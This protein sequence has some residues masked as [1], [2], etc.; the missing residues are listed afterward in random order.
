MKNN[1]LPQTPSWLDSILWGTSLLEAAGCDTPRLDA[2]ILL[3]HLLDCERHELYLKD[4]RTD[5]ATTGSEHS[6]SLEKFRGVIHRR[7]EREPVSQ[8]LGYK[9]F[10]SLKI[11]VTKE[12]LTPRPETEAVVE[13]A[14]QVVATD[15]PHIL[16]LCTGSGCIAAALATELPNATFLV[17]D[18]CEK[19]LSVARENLDFHKHRVT[20]VQSN[21]FEKIRGDFD[22][23]VS[24]P[25]YLPTETYKT[26]MPEVSVWEP[27]LAHDGGKDGL[28]LVRQIRQG[29]PN[30]LKESGHLIIESGPNIETWKNLSS[31]AGKLFKVV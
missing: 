26:A 23:I 18:I 27:Q 3:A 28:D 17:A 29:A 12:V 15:K 10:W 4:M 30:Y 7:M 16:D 19:T 1:V 24:N 2:E 21:L 31:P 20:F 25:P 22:L 8:I 13:K 11:K 9:D 6:V 14:L 5:Q